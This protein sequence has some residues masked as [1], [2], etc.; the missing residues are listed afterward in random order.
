M[1]D[2]MTALA[3]TPPPARYT[4]EPVPDDL[5]VML[6]AWNSG[7]ATQRAVAL[8]LADA[9]RRAATNKEN[10]IANRSR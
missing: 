5:F 4:P 8:E 6:T 2:G 1:G 9:N 3:L 10:A 7:S